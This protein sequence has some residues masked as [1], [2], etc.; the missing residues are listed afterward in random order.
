[1]LS[2]RRHVLL[3]PCHGGKFITLDKITQTGMHVCSMF[4]K[5][6][7]ACHR[8]ICLHNRVSDMVKKRGTAPGALPTPVSE[9]EWV[10]RK[11]RQ[12]QEL[13]LMPLL[14]HDQERQQHHC[15]KGNMQAA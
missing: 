12:M 9:Q 4:C 8:T 11:A 2:F 3:M 14:F 13:C 15:S 1:M 6:I 10:W 5:R 7:I